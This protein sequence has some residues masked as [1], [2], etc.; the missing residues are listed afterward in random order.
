MNEEGGSFRVVYVSGGP[1]PPSAG[2][3]AGAHSTPQTGYGTLAG[4]PKSQP[5]TQP[6]SQSQGGSSSQQ[7]TVTQ[8]PPKRTEQAMPKFAEGDGAGPSDGL[9][10]PSYAE[11]VQGDNKIQSHE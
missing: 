5:P 9:A 1:P 4:A 3:T 7:R 11:V 10:P 8:Q 6:S 2:P